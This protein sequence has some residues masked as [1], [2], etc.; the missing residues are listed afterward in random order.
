M[1]NIG[2]SAREAVDELDRQ[3]EPEG[4]VVQD[5]FAAEPVAVPSGVNTW[6]GHQQQLVD[7]GEKRFQ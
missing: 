2:G 4:V 6:S 1:R 7:T 3:G 5:V